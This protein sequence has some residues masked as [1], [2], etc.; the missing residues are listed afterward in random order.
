MIVLL[1][2][3]SPS[4]ITPRSTGWAEVLEGAYL[5]RSNIDDRGDQQLWKAYIQLT[6]AE[7]ASH[8]ERSARRPSDLASARGPR[9]GRYPRLLS[10]LCAVEEPR[11][12]AERRRPWKFAAHDHRRACA[13]RVDYVVLPTTTHGEIGLRCVTEPDPAQAALSIVLASSYRNARPA[14]YEAPNVAATA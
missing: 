2:S 11:D 12:V 13:H 5:L 14:E 4:L 10:C 7:A 3:G 8:P 9:S 6:Q 1:G